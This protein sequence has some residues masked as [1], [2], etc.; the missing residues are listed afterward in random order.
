MLRQFKSAVVPKRNMLGKAPRRRITMNDVLRMDLDYDREELLDLL[1]RGHLLPI[2]GA[3]ESNQNQV[4]AG[5]N[6]VYFPKAIVVSTDQTVLQGDLVWWDPINYTLKQCTSQAQVALGATGGLAGAA[7][8]TN[9]PGVYPNPAAG[10]P[11]ENLPGVQVQRGGSVY[12]NSTLGDGSY[13]PF[14]PVTIGVDQQTISRGGQTTANRVGFVIVAPP[15]VARS[16]PGAT[17]LPE[18][19]AGGARVEVLLE[20]KFPNTVLL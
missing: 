17:P 16:G 14:E 8:G 1:D 10:T 7:A 15:V 9:V 13:F 4:A 2:L 12:L 18:T 20:A 6:P 19:V 5:A 3:A 11:S